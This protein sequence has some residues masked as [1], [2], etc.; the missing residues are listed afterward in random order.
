M[1]TAKPYLKSDQAHINLPLKSDFNNKFGLNEQTR[2][3]KYRHEDYEAAG[4][5]IT[6][7]NI[8]TTPLLTNRF[9]FNKYF[10]AY[11]LI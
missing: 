1:R 2:S 9:H 5:V 11:Q 8:I 10:E 6:S 3:M 7:G 4:E